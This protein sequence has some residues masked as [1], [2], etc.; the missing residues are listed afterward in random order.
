MR[1]TKKSL[2][3][4]NK[5]NQ[6]EIEVKMETTQAKEITHYLHFSTFFQS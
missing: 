3:A 5:S 2:K 4:H 6:T 1:N